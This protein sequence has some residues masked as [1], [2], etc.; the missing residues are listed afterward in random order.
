[1]SYYS[2]SR[3]SHE[4]FNTVAAT[5]YERQ[6]EILNYVIKSSANA[7]AESPNPKIK[8]FGAQLH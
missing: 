5:I 7:S 1:M 8:H 6:G 4:N 2:K 3:L